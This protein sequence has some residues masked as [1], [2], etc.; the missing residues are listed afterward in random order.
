MGYA[1]DVKA[2]DSE[3]YAAVL[4][5]REIQHAAALL[6]PHFTLKGCTVRCKA[7]HIAKYKLAIE[8][9]KPAGKFKFG[10]T[11][12]KRHYPQWTADMSTATYVQFYAQSN[13]NFGESPFAVEDLVPLP[14][15][16][17]PYED[18]SIPDGYD[19]VADDTPVV[20]GDTFRPSP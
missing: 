20:T 4:A 9:S 5:A 13:R 1:E 12:G 7:E 15:R 8:K 6:M 2:R 18:P 17:S 16:P 3:R 10:R 14:D 19:E 11:A